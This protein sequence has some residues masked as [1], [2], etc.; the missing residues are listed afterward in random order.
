MW[1]DTIS[2]TKQIPDYRFRRVD[3]NLTTGEIRQ[4][5]PTCD[6]MEDFLGGIGRSFKIL[7]DYDVNDA[8]DRAAPLNYESGYLLWHGYDDRAKNFLLRLQPSQSRK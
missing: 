2:E 4:T 1:T 5:S 3:L 8:F 6:D 7:A